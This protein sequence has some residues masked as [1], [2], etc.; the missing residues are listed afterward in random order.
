MH[1]ALGQYNG[2]PPAREVLDQ[3]EMVKHWH[4]N[5]MWMGPSGIGS[6]RGLK[7]FEAYRQFRFSIGISRPGWQ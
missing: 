7:G 4:T 6:T 5:F 2:Q 1:A 3:M